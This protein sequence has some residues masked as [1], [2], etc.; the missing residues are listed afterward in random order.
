M[1]TAGKSY[2]IVLQIHSE[3]LYVLFYWFLEYYYI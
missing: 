2:L 1:S 3:A